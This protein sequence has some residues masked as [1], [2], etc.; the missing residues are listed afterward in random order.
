MG[1]D[2]LDLLVRTLPGEEIDEKALRDRL[3]D[4]ILPVGT[5]TVITEETVCAFLPE[6]SPKKRMRVRKGKENGVSQ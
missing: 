6:R 4:E 2:S 3:T 5:K 1:E